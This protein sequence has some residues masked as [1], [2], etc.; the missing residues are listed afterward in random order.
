MIGGTFV[1][2]ARDDSVVIFRSDKGYRFYV[3]QLVQEKTAQVSTM[4][5]LMIARTNRMEEI[6]KQVPLPDVTA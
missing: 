3:D 1:R 5:S 6:L 4:N 2:F